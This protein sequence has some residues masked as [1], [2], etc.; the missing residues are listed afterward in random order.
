MNSC[1][2]LRKFLEP[3]DGPHRRSAIVRICDVC[4]VHQYTV[5]RWRDGN[6]RIRPIF[7]RAI[8]EEFNREI[9][10]L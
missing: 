9:F 6:V 2:E 1:D 7:K 10:K 8:N 5:K 3:M 4:E